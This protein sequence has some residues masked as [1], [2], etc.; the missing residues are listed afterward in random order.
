MTFE[1]TESIGQQSHIQQHTQNLPLVFL[2]HKLLIN[3][4]CSLAKVKFCVFGR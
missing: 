2:I 4:L 3:C 1:I